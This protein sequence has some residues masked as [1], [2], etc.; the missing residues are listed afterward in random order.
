MAKPFWIST[1]GFCFF[2][3][4]ATAAPSPEALEFFEKKVRPVLVDQ[5][6][7]CHTAANKT[8]G[9]DLSS[10]EGFVHG[11][12][13]GALVDTDHPEASLLLKVLSYEERLKMPPM[14]KL[15]DAA[16][17]DIE[18]WIKMGA[19]WP[20]AESIQPRQT[21]NAAEGRAFTKEEREYW[22]FQPVADP[23]PPSVRQTDW[24]RSPVD[25]YILAK[26]EGKGLPAP[27]TA[28]KHALLRRVTFD[29][30]GLPPS[31]AEIASFLGD[32][33]PDALEKVVDRLLASPRYGER[34]GRRWLD[35]ARYADSTG[36]DEDHRYPYAWRYRDYV[37][38]AFNSDMPF[39]QFVVEQVA[40]D[41][42]PPPPGETINRRGLIATGLLSL[43]PKAVAQQDKQKMLYDIYDEQVDVVSK[44]FLGMTVS[45]ARCHDHKFDAILQS[46]YYSLAGIFAGTKN[47]AKPETHVSQL[48]F[49]P[50]VPKQEHEEYQKWRNELFTARMDRYDLLDG[51][52]EKYRKSNAHDVTALLLAARRAIEDG[53]SYR[54][55]AAEFRVPADAVWDWAGFLLRNEDAEYLA[56]WRNAESPMQATVAALALQKSFSLEANAWHGRLTRWRK[57]YRARAMTMTI[58]PPGRPEYEREDNAFFYD[59][60]LAEN[61][62]VALDESGL[63]GKLDQDGQRA[64]DEV[65]TL[66]AELEARDLPEPDLACAVVEG[67]P[68][69]QKLFIRGDYNALG[70]STPPSHPRIFGDNNRFDI[71]EGQSGRLQLAEW[72][73]SADNPLTPRV[74]VNRVWQGHFGEGIVRTP[75]NWGTTG[76]APTHPKLLDYLTSRFLEDGW[77]IKKLHKRILMSNAY[78]MSAATTPA[79]FDADPENLLLSR[80]HRRRLDIEEIRDGLLAATGSLDPTM[81]GTMQ[82]GF[83]TDSENSSSRLSVD[84]AVSKRRMVYLPLRRANLPALLNLFDFGD[85]ASSVGKRPMTTVAPQALFM[86]NS[87]F[88]ASRAGDLAEDLMEATADNSERLSKAYLRTLTREPGQAEVAKGLTF[89][90]AFQQRFGGDEKAAWQSLC[91]ILMASNEFVYVD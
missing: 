10:A 13:S 53:V 76:E 56:D 71:P 52:A 47:F 91:R 33:S 34:W 88:I 65:T 20:G 48:L 7:M 83:G 11:G 9:L 35:V 27:E 3:V 54:L 4:A 22:A 37:I 67:K 84:P 26:L 31:E 44:A 28:T 59:A 69:E 73:A 43:G 6:Q 79:A 64:F 36:N 85:A 8:A 19:P 17:A 78:R 12:E 16:R 70:Q 42:L 89:L 72:L 30:T 63:R 80:F 24:V 39:N 18:A 90:E 32:N 46:D 40:G 62:P 61:G 23:A 51:S 74:I 5:C 45:C 21:T 77:S 87:D 68:V 41:L 1:L 57:Q 50:L 82:S 55:A 14:G 15:D 49:T 75:S 66:L 86:M 38:E 29:L 25:R 60:A 58:P 2:S 81:G